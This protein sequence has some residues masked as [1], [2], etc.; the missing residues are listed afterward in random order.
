MSV[1]VVFQV[2]GGV[3][4]DDSSALSG[5]EICQ[6]FVLKSDV[7]SDGGQ[8]SSEKCS[9]TGSSSNGSFL[10]LS[11]SSKSSSLSS[12]DQSLSG[13]NFGLHLSVD[14]SDDGYF[15]NDWSWNVD[16]PDD[17]LFFDHWSVDVM[18]FFLSHDVLHD[19]LSDESLGWCL[20]HLVSDDLSVLSVMNNIL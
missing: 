8:S 12:Q 4:V 16:F 9:R 7:T 5:G 3:L 14:S 2:N 1:G 6:S 13:E 17:L 19:G 10:E 18:N 11:G 20:K 15:L